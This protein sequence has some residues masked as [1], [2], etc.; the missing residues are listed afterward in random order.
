MNK[1]VN[2]PQI[3]ALLNGDE[4]TMHLIY[5]TLYPKVKIFVYR[6]KGNGHDAEEI[7][8]NALFQLIAKAKVKGIQ[9]NTSF[10]A[11]FFTVCKNLW[12]Q[13]LNKRNKEVRNDG[14]FELKDENDDHIE[15]ILYQERWDLFEETLLELSENCQKLLKD[16]F[17]KVSYNEIIKKFSYSTKNVAFQRIFKCKKQLTKLIKKNSRFKNL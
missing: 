8:H 6:N 11:Y 3:I 14:V 2:H 10:E 4:K 9:I 12:Y 16:Y 17:N 5:N 15:S 1:I 7:F 13:E